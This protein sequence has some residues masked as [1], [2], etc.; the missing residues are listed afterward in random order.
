LWNLVRL[1]AA[2]G[3]IIGA[4]IVQGSWTNRWG[5]PPA[6]AALAARFD[7]VPMTIGDWTA[8]PFEIGARERKLAGAEACLSRVYTNDRRGVSVSVLLLAGLPGDIATHTPDICYRGAGYE[9]STPAAFTHRSP[10]EERGAEF[11]TARAVRGGANPSVLRIFWTWRSAK[12]WGAPGDARWKFAS[13]PMLS[14]L[15]V[16]RETGGVDVETDRD[17]CNDFLNVLLPEL[18][19]AVY[20]PAG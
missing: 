15:Y 10:G 12:G 18:D 6:L 17:P 13:E 14:K 5:T 2:A 8:V 16:V 19:R 11:R 9:L 4:G 3:L 7:T 1:T 20:S